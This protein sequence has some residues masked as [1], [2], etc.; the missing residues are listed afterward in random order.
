[1]RRTTSPQIFKR[2]RQQQ[3]H[4]AADR[5]FGRIFDRHHGIMA[6]PDSTSR[7]TSSIEPCGSRRAAWP[8]CLVAADSEKVPSGPRKAMP[9]GSSSDRQADITSRKKKVMFSPGSGPGIG[10]L[11]AA[12]HLGFALGAVDVPGL[13]VFGLDLAD[14]LRTAGALV[15]QAQQFTVDAVDFGAHAGQCLLQIVAHGRSSYPLRLAK[16][17]MKS[18][19]ACTPS[20]GTAL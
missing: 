1:M 20:S 15:E 3:V 13:A 8:K 9:S 10:F 17:F 16:S 6:W 2:R 14:L 7:K 4:R 18:T 11:Q 12:Q 19:S 5:A